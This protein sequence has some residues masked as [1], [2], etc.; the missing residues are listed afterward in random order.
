MGFPAEPYSF[1]NNF[2]LKLSKNKIQSLQDALAR[3][4]KNGDYA[5]VKRVLSILLLCK[6]HLVSE[7][8]TLLNV[9]TQA[10]RDWL[11]KYFLYGIHGLRSGKITGRPPKLTKSQRRELAKV[12]KEGPEKAGFPGACWRTP[13]LQHLINEKYGV[14]YNTRY[15][16]ELLKNMNF[17]FQ[18]AK[19]AKVCLLS[20]AGNRGIADRKSVV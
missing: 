3:A 13:M 12:I 18:K 19:A 4:E 15:I 9:S 7:I 10:V 2:K 20:I 6:D 11:K 16:S 1:S 17:S 14:F 5:K 8:A